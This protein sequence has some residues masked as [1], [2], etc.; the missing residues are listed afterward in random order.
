[1]NKTPAQIQERVPLA[2]G[3]HAAAIPTCSSHQCNTTFQSLIAVSNRN[4]KFLSPGPSIQLHKNE[5]HEVTEP[6]GHRSAD[7]NQRDGDPNFNFDPG[8]ARGIL[9]MSHLSEWRRRGN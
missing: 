1:M 4:I 2:G 7:H 5:E 6:G 8:D 9:S 3:P